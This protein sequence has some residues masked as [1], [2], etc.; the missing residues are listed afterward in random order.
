MRILLLAILIAFI[1]Y[2]ASAQTAESSSTRNNYGIYADFNSNLHSA[3]FRRLPGVPNCCPAFESGSG[4]GFSIGTLFELPIA[5]GFFLGWRAG[6]SSID[7]RLS[8]I[9][10]TS[11]ILGEMLSTGE[12]EHVIDSRISTIGVEQHAGYRI[13]EGFS[14]TLG[15]RAASILS[16]D[17]EQSETI[18]KPAGRATFANE[19]GSDSRSAIRNQSSGEL[20]EAASMN[21][22]LMGMVSYSL[23]LNAE[24]TLTLN[25]E[26]SYFYG[27]SNLVTERDWTANAFKFGAAIKYSPKPG[28]EIEY[29]E[30]I[31]IDTVEIEVPT[32]GRLAKYAREIFEGAPTIRLDTTK[33]Q[34]YMIITENY[35][36]TDTLKKFIEMASIDVR[37]VGLTESG[38]EM[39]DATFRIEEFT[40]SHLEP[41][42]NYIFFEEGSAKIPDRYKLLKDSYIEKFEPND[43]FDKST[44]ETYYQILNIVGYRMR[45]H[46]AAKLTITGCNAGIGGEK[47]D[48]GL[49]MR[50]AESVRDYLINKWE[51]AGSRI[52]VESRNLPS[53][54][55]TPIGEPDKIAENRRAELHSDTY[56]ILA[57]IYTENTEYRATPP[58]ARFYIQTQ[59]AGHIKA[60]VLT[61]SQPGGN[62]PLMKTAFD[63]SP[64]DTI[65]WELPGV[66]IFEDPGSRRIEYQAALFGPYKTHVSDSGALDIEI[67]TIKEKKI[68]KIKDRR[69]DRFRLILFDFD[70]AEIE[71]INARIIDMINEQLS[72]KSAISIIG[73][74]DRTGDEKHNH[75]L[76]L[77]RAESA[78]RAINYP[79]GQIRGLGES[80]LIFPNDLPEGR[81]YCRTVVIYAETP[82]D[83]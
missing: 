68:R 11:I 20:P 58:R 69:I 17:Y 66:K 41:L 81:F 67:Y 33:Q 62:Q 23:P 29:R 4:G 15:F 75:E 36:R 27:L 39:P 53:Q 1:A 47:D 65:D 21:F 38:E 71:G 60:S 55:S 40:A 31:Y 52:S 63:I 59:D 83:Q 50:R 22:S 78:A 76:S 42:L 13:T 26:I 35:F 3:N 5:D 37:A 25:P 2:N 57:P 46:P 28:P 82:L 79:S 74:T 45:Q 43:L 77:R 73:Y 51:I 7:A 48:A 49:S 32:G 14:V 19:D 70:R 12:F 9:E 8:K 24:G 56:E 80:E 54:P 30:N 10:E 64:A 34:N 72:E 44:L 16:A 61:V 18:V 6:Y